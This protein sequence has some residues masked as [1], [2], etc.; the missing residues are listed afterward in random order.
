[1]RQE[2]TVQS[3]L[4]LYGLPRGAKSCLLQGH[5]ATRCVP[6]RYVMNR[7]NRIF[8]A[9]E[10]PLLLVTFLHL[11]SRDDHSGCWRNRIVTPAGRHTV[12]TP[13]SIFPAIAC[14]PHPLRGIHSVRE[15]STSTEFFDQK[16][17]ENH[18]PEAST[19]ASMSV[20]ENCMR[21]CMRRS[22]RRKRSCDCD[23]SCESGPSLLLKVRHRSKRFARSMRKPA[24]WASSVG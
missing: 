23:R 24:I 9:V 19:E 1:V 8:S 13:G 10:R 17:R 4:C 11:T 15:S 5:R 18:G 20:L 16:Y 21:V 6:A 3:L 2:D 22:F 14:G 12:W 7:T